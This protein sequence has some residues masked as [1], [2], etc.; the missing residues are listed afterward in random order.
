MEVVAVKAVAMAKVVVV[1]KGV[2]VGQKQV[3]QAAIASAPSVATASST[4]LDN[5]VT[6]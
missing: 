5:H 1:V 3:G 2:A 4:R 6:S